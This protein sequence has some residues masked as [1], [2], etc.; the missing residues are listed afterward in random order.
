MITERLNLSGPNSYSKAFMNLQRQIDQLRA[1][2]SPDMLTSNTTNG[3]SRRPKIPVQ[4][5]GSGSEDKDFPVNEL[6]VCVKLAGG[7]TR[8]GF[9]RGRFTQV[10]YKDGS[11]NPVD[12][13][14]NPVDDLPDITG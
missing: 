8:E 10:F 9:V 7:G 4:K 2:R 6:S 5:S 11:G 1:T 14:G 3:V 12:E 13:S